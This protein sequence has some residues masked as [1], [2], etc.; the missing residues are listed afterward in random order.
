LNEEVIVVLSDEISKLR[1]AL[2]IT[3][4]SLLEFNH[5]QE[6]GPRW[7]T[8]GEDGMYAQVYM[9]LHKGLEAINSCR[10]PGFNP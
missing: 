7:Y 1:G 10:S 9:W 6:S 8:R 3:H 5:A 2:K 4:Q